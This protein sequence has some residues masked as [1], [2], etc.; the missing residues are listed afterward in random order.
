MI[1]YLQMKQGSTIKTKILD[2][3]RIFKEKNPGLYK[4]IPKF[5]LSYV[6]RITHQDELNDLL[7]DNPGLYGVDFGEACTKKFNVSYDSINLDKIDKSGR[8]LF[9]ANHPLGGLDG[10]IFMNI[11]GRFFKNIKFPVNDILLHI[12]RFNDIFIPINKHGS[13]ARSAAQQIE[14]TFA[15]ES[16]VLFFP[17]GLVSRKN[18]GVIKDLEWKAAFVK[19]SIKYKRDI[20]PVYIDA[21]NS[22]F[23]YNLARLRGK[24]GIKANIE[25][26]YLVDEMFKQEGKKINFSFGKPIKWQELENGDSAKKWAEKI[27]E[28]TYRLPKL[29]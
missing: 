16:Q 21:Q 14:S 28:T 17:A 2:I 1:E 24:L 4:W 12:G 18:N 8:Y 7:N 11:M 25:M 6:K 19:K 10:I 23:F 9:V 13:Q 26:L 15:S 22:K 29:N 20:V 5:V 27:K 3:D